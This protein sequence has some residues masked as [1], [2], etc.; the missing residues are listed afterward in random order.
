MSVISETKKKSNTSKELEN[1]KMIYS[2]I[3]CEEWASSGVAILI[4]IFT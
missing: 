3:P 2:G 1:Y 4:R